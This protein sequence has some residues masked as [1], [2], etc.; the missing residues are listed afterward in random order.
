MKLKYKRDIHMIFNIPRL[1][2][3]ESMV[4]VL[5][6]FINFFKDH[7]KK[8]PPRKAKQLSVQLCRNLKSTF[9]NVSLYMELV[10]SNYRRARHYE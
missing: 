4:Y 6:L 1:F 3:S 9:I 5:S 8:C 2:L 7:N 10:S